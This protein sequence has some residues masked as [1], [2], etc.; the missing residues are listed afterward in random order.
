MYVK[1]YPTNFPLLKHTHTHSAP[2][3]KKQKKVKKRE[4]K[5]KV[6]KAMESTLTTFVQYQ[7]ESGKFQKRE[8]ERWKNEMELEEKRR[9]IR[10]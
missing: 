6:E 10:T 5:S 8:D 3:A 7:V 2:P 1:A 4:K 9:N